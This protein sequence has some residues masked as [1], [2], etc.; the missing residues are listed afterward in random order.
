M[1]FME[2]QLPFRIKSEPVSSTRMIYNLLG[3]KFTCEKGAL[4]A[5][6]RQTYKTSW[7]IHSETVA[8]CTGQA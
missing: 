6:V 3:E 8:A 5:D 2:S 4:A 7:V 1:R